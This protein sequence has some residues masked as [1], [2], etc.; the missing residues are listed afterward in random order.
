MIKEIS[1]TFYSNDLRYSQIHDRVCLVDGLRYTWTIF[2]SSDDGICCGSGQGSYELEMN[3][4]RLASGGD[5]A[6]SSEHTFQ[7]STSPF[8]W[9]ELGSDIDGTDKY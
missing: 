4:V 2:D 9:I 8:H 5:F 7:S 3:G 6:D 1:K